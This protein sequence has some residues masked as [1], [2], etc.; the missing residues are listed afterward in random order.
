MAGLSVAGYHRGRSPCRMFVEPPINF[1]V[2][3]TKNI[4]HILFYISAHPLENNLYTGGYAVLRYARTGTQRRDR[5][6][7]EGEGSGREG[8]RGGEAG[9]GAT[10]ASVQ[11]G[12][13]QL[14]PDTRK[15]NTVAPLG[16]SC[17]CVRVLL[18][19][20]VLLVGVLGSGA[21]CA[22]VV[23]NSV[24]FLELLMFLSELTFCS[25]V[26]CGSTNIVSLPAVIN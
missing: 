12:P 21:V 9:L 26:S 8:P 15:G 19:S 3:K 14:L 7:E 13:S 23:I 5:R 20:L 4:Y 22:C 11:S 25:D 18:P 2:L 6:E 10:G 1:S 16:V 24:R 17:V